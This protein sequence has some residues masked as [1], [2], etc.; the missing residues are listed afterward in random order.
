[1]LTYIPLD[2]AWTLMN[3]YICSYCT[4]LPTSPVN[5]RAPSAWPVYHGGAHEVL[6]SRSF[7]PQGRVMTDPVICLTS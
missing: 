3:V 7:L 1:M 4:V 2:S 6:S 5:P